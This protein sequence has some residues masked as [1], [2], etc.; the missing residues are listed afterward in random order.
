[1]NIFKDGNESAVTIFYKIKLLIVEDL[2]QFH[3]QI[4]LIISQKEFIKLN[5]ETVIVK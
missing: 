3:Y 5:G 4:L 2:R 1:M